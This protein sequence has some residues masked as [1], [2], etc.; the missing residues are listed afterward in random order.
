MKIGVQATL[1]ASAFVLFSSLCVAHGGRYIGPGDLVPP[2]GGSGG[3]GGSGSPTGPTTGDPPGPTAPRP[4]GPSGNGTNP[5][6]GGGRQP[7]GRPGGRTG[8][9]GMPIEVDNLAEWDFWWEINKAPYL[10]LKD[11]V[12][13]AD[14]VTGSDDIYI[15][16]RRGEGRDS[17]QPTSAEIRDTVL[18]ALHRAIGS[19]DNR[20]IVSSCMVA[21]AKIG[22]N[23]PDFTL[24]DVFAP[25]LRSPDQELRETAALAI[26]IAAIPGERELDLLVGLARDDAAGRA[27]AKGPVDPRSRSFALYGLGLLA[28]RVADARIKRRAFDTMRDVLADDSIANRNI[29]VAAIQGIGILAIDGSDKADAALLGEAVACLEGYYLRRLGAGERLIQAHCPTA[30]AKLLGRDHA[31]APRFCAMFAAD[32][33]ATGSKERGDWITQ[34]CALALG[35]LVRPI[36]GKDAPDAPWGRALLDAYKN[37]R[38]AQ[39]RWFAAMALGQ[40]GGRFCRDALLECFDKAS[41]NQQRSWCALALGVLSFHRAEQADEYAGEGDGLVRATLID[42]FA[43]A[44]DPSLVGALAIALGLCRATEAAPALRERMLG[45]LPQ[46]RMAGYLC[47]GLALMRDRSSMEDIRKAFA[48][49]SRG[50]ELLP[51]AAIALGLLG[52]KRAASDLERM[53]GAENLNLATFAAIASAIGFI[54]D[55]RSIAPLEK[56]LFESRI[57]LAR[58]FAAVALGGIADKEPLPWNSKIGVGA[59]Y[60]ANVETLTNQATGIL[61]IL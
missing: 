19:T 52:D 37:H 38:D 51:Q 49:P 3:G 50:G 11:A 27:A 36:E 1:C 6:T 2:G 40:I 22:Q 10:R 23:H 18:P 9:R 20:D 48:R 58:A 24:V 59:N 14:P 15:G 17:M 26:G 41:Q 61:D 47:V 8:G 30:I 28:H 42:A 16:P 53:L 29:K 46:E 44:K 25:R 21:M 32:L 34:S 39:T 56:T 54:G 43:T 13:A 35:R 57:D 55:R 7:D 4:S 33:Q 5:T 12:H 60:R 45:N 31:D